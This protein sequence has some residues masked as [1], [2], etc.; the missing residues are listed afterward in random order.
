MNRAD[1]AVRQCE[2]AAEDMQVAPLGVHACMLGLAGRPDEARA[3]LDQLK[4]EVELRSA[5]PY[6]MALGH[7]GLGDLEGAL[8]G[9][10]KAV[11]FR[12]RNLVTLR[13]DPVW[14][15]VRDRQRFIDLSETIVDL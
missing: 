5:D 15:P 9:L 2:L 3:L 7:L 6:E 8:G 4:P 10:E 1:D 13:S 11:E 14:N 12:S